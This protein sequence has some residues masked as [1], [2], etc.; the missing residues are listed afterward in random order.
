MLRERFEQIYF[1]AGA[2]VCASCSLSLNAQAGSRDGRDRSLEPRAPTRFDLTPTTLSH[3]PQTDQEGGAKGRLQ[4]QREESP[5][6]DE[7]PQRA[8]GGD[9]L[10]Q[11]RQERPDQQAD[12]EKGGQVDEHAGGHQEDELDTAWREGHQ[13]KC[14]DRYVYT[15]SVHVHAWCIRR[16]VSWPRLKV[17]GRRDSLVCTRRFAD[18]FPRG[19]LRALS[20]GGEGRHG[21]RSEE[22]SDARSPKSATGRVPPE[23][24]A[25]CWSIRPFF[26]AATDGVLEA[27]RPAPSGQ[28]CFCF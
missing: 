8:R 18:T 7:P 22:R 16:F 3:Q 19:Y 20:S 4:G 10:P 14:W 13:G 24:G 2:E 5:Q 1:L 15:V 28:P 26:V 17:G 9:R 12:R 21:E 27:H 11:R 25:R 6:G 23:Q